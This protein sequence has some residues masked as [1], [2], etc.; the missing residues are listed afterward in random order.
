MTPAE[1]VIGFTALLAQAGI[2][3]FTAEEVVWGRGR[4]EKSA[5][6]RAADMAPRTV[7]LLPPLRFVWYNMI[8]T[9]QA[10]Q[11]LRNKVGAGVSV[12]S[13][14]RDFLYNEAVGG[15]PGSQHLSFR[16][17]DLTVRGMPAPEVYDL[18]CT[19]PSAHRMG[20]G[21]YQTFT[22]IDTRGFRARW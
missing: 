3:S 1:Y 9:L 5:L 18:L 10:A 11:W 13:G 22:H 17:L 4:R 19:H 7:Y 16:A 6:L 12:T 15:A 8:P 20:L 14:Y 2:T 21:K